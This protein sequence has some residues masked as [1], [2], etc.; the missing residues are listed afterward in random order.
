MNSFSVDELMLSFDELKPFSEVL[1][2]DI[3][4]YRLHKLYKNLDKHDDDA[5]LRHILVV[6]SC[7]EDCLHADPPLIKMLQNCLVEMTS[8]IEKTKE[9]S[10]KNLL[11]IATGILFKYSAALLQI[12]EDT[13]FELALFLNAIAYHYLSS[14]LSTEADVSA[15]IAL[16]TLEA[17]AAIT[18]GYVVENEDIELC[19]RDD[20]AEFCVDSLI[21]SDGRIQRLHA[22]V[23]RDAIAAAPTVWPTITV[24]QVRKMF[25]RLTPVLSKPDVLRIIVWM[26]GHDST[27]EELSIF[28]SLLMRSNAL[29]KSNDLDS[30]NLSG[31]DVKCFL[32][33][34]SLW[35]D[36]TT[37]PAVVPA[38]LRI[39]ADQNNC[40]R[41]ICQLLCSN[42]GNESVKSVLLRSRVIDSVRLRHRVVSLR[43]LYEVFRWLETHIKNHQWLMLYAT[44]I[45]EVITGA[46]SHRRKCD[47]LFPDGVDDDADMSVDEVDRIEEHVSRYIALQHLSKNEFTRAEHL[48]IYANSFESKK[49]LLKVYRKWLEEGT[50]E[51]QERDQLSKRVRELEIECC[52]EDLRGR[53]PSTNSAASI[54]SADETV[55]SAIPPGTRKNLVDACTNTPS[56]VDTSTSCGDDASFF[57]AKSDRS[58]A[59]MHEESFASAVASP[60]APSSGKPPLLPT[61]QIVS[62][63]PIGYQDHATQHPDGSTFTSAASS[64]APTKAD[65]AVHFGSIGHPQL[66]ATKPVIASSP[67]S[68]R[69]PP[70]AHR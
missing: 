44:A 17:G 46:P 26:I 30:P 69:S 20:L 70:L 24:M 42:S 57:S 47:D 6:V 23:Y 28:D 52:E 62:T 13:D 45:N 38:R 36:S 63:T 55:A 3:Q 15:W 48:L 11:A 60:Y 19:T 8:L 61:S 68:Y 37:D 27:F 43:R 65:D 34:L 31:T 50:L 67:S 10:S 59:V 35:S 32:F 1:H 53:T 33:T 14:A 66:T 2:D 40:W 64:T 12:Q 54:T 56:R 5:L 25:E 16:H 7:M 29:S 58:G 41:A 39:R 9:S 49:L 4:L 22:G 18:Y 21:P 51:K